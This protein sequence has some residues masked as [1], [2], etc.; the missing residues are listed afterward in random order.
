MKR[1]K[2]TVLLTGFPRQASRLALNR[3]LAEGRRVFLLCSNEFAD[4]ARGIIGEGNGEVFLGRCSALDLGLSGEEV[5]RLQSEVEEVHHLEDSYHGSP[6]TM[7]QVLI[8]GTR[9]LLEFSLDLPRLL[10]FV[11]YS[12]AFSVGWKQ[13]LVVANAPVAN[14]RRWHN[15]YEK[16]RWES[17]R[18]ARSAM[19]QLPVTIIRSGLLVGSPDSPLDATERSFHLLKRFVRRSVQL[20]LPLPDGGRHCLHI[21]PTDYLLSITEGLLNHKGSVGATFHVTDPT[22]PSAQEVLLSLGGKL[23][24]EE[25][26]LA[27]RVSSWVS[28]IPGASPPPGAIQAYVS[29]EIW[30]ELGATRATLEGTT[31]TCPAFA[32]YSE[33]LRDALGV[34]IP[35]KEVK[36]T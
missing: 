4:E 1:K 31:L 32:K 9:S 19:H 24:A 34:G 29:H 30:F 15:T 5:K 18:W 10:R 26:P 3:F 22:P 11:H 36:K 7:R 17:E 13:G 21:C 25:S 14:V 6:S 12:S 23:P 28:R 35:T 2:G 27:D 16:L 33:S 20:P 8:E